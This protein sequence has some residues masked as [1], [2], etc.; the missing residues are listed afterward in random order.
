M[1]VD[2]SLAARTGGQR[3]NKWKWYAIPAP[4]I[5]L[6]LHRRCG[7]VGINLT[8]PPGD[9]QARSPSSASTIH[10]RAPP[11]VSEFC[12]CWVVNCSTLNFLLPNTL[13]IRGVG[14][15]IYDKQKV[16]GWLLQHIPASAPEGHNI[17]L[18]SLY[19]AISAQ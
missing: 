19:S 5:D 15:S 6:R 3:G 4:V 17:R 11:R 9:I 2:N 16:I 7:G 13:G 18:C 8:T 12:V 10:P 14:G 1:E